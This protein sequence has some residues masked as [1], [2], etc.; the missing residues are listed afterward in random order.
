MSPKGL[1]LEVFAKKRGSFAEH[2]TDKP[3]S[4]PRPTLSQFQKPQNQEIGEFYIVQERFWSSKVLWMS[5]LQTCRRIR[6]FLMKMKQQKLGSCQL[7][8][9]RFPAKPADLGM[10]SISRLHQCAKILILPRPTIHVLWWER[11]STCHEWKPRNKT[12]NILFWSLTSSYSTR[13]RENV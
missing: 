12:G 7:I 11:I 1:T 9:W 13:K 10:G 3:S 2:C 6:S 5:G 8:W 4:T